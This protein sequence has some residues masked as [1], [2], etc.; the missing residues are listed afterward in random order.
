MSAH[1]RNAAGRAEG[2]EQAQRLVQIAAE[3]VDKQFAELEQI[4]LTR[5]V[6]EAMRQLFGG[7]PHMH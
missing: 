3:N 1:P 6:D 7:L 4:N 5:A 2:L